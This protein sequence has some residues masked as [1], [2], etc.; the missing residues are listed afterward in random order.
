VSGTA[1]RTLHCEWHCTWNGSQN[2]YLFPYKPLT[3]H[4]LQSNC[5]IT[6]THNSV[7]SLY[8]SGYAE[9]QAVA[10]TEHDRQFNTAHCVYSYNTATVQLQYSCS[11]A[12]V[13]LQY[14]YSTATVQLQYSCSTA[15]VQLQCLMLTAAP[16]LFIYSPNFFCPQVLAIFVQPDVLLLCAVY[17]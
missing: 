10:C 7:Y 14:S 16:C 12:T 6:P 5:C 2:T 4:S 1:H 11:T 3:I 13:Q 8:S 15:T 9:V 17:M